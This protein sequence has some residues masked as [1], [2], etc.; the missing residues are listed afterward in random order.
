MSGRRLEEVTALLQAQRDELLW[1]ADGRR[2]AERAGVTLTPAGFY[3]PA[4]TLEEVDASFEYAEA[5]PFMDASV[6]DLRRM[7]AELESLTP[8]ADEYSPPANGDR[9][10]PEGFFWGLGPFGDADALAYYA[11]LRRERPAVVLEVGSG[12]S[13]LVALEALR[14]NGSG[15]VVCVEPYP[16]AYLR[17]LPVELVEQPVQT[18]SP[19]FFNATLGDGD[20][21]FIDSTHTVKTGSDCVHLYLRV[22]PRLAARTWVHV[23]DV[24]LPFGLPKDWLAEQ[25]LYWAEQYLLMAYLLDNPRVEVTYASVANRRLLPERQQRFVAGKTRPG[26]GS[27]WFV[28]APR[29]G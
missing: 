27:L 16:P 22:L 14:C 6:F 28:Q 29:S 20:V 15:R 10:R 13:T 2:A 11:M 24:F 25:H 17:Q 18:L 8:F 9:E 26:G 12:A 4:P 5:A 3:Y 7:A 19:E 1:T 23:H 21:L